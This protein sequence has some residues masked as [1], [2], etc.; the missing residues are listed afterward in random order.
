MPL[1]LLKRSEKP[2]GAENDITEEEHDANLSLIESA[3]LEL[4]ARAASLE[5]EGEETPGSAV[6]ET[7]TAGFSLGSLSN[8]S[9]IPCS[10]TFTATI[11]DAASL[12]EGFTAD[13]L[14][15]AGTVTLDG[16]GATNVALAAGE[17]GSVFVLAG[18]VWV[19]RGTLTRID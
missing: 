5:G 18:R 4:E 17:F 19:A 2:A 16:P 12:G 7:R 10:G 8:G 3:V 9:L 1:N 11:P 13:V 15:L 6:E 14:V